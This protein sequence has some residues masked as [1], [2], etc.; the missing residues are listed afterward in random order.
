MI[1]R[2]IGFVTL[3]R[4]DRECGR[5]A[6]VEKQKSIIACPSAFFDVG[7][8]LKFNSFERIARLTGTDCPV[9]QQGLHVQG[10]SD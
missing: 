5:R 8:V 10:T 7:S 6:D 3:H 9:N 4:N 1:Y 2:I